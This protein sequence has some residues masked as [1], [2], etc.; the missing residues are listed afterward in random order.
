MLE[1]LDKI[2]NRT[3]R[4][5]QRQFLIQVGIRSYEFNYSSLELHN[6]TDYFLKA[7]KRGLSPYKAL[8]FFYDYLNG[9]YKI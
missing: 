9:D 8:L 5:R 1:L 2:L 3:N 6:N 4:V 7:F